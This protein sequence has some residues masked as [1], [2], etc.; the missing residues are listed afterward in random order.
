MDGCGDYRLVFYVVFW[1]GYEPLR[2]QALLCYWL[3]ER[4]GLFG[5]G[6]LVLMRKSIFSGSGELTLY[7]RIYAIRWL[8]M[9]HKGAVN[10]ELSVT[11]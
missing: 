3:R 8:Y 5:S 2:T 1:C 11:L 6:D 10:R 4:V 9:S 7:L